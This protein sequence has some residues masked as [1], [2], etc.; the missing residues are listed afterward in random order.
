MAFNSEDKISYEELAPSLQAILNNSI[1]LDT[2]N[3]LN[4]K[5]NNLN[6]YVN[7]FIGGLDGV[8]ISITT[9]LNNISSPVNNKELA[10]IYNTNGAYVSMYIYAAG[11]WKI[12]HAVYA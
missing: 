10:F 6:A 8:R 3:V 11:S 9:S 5:I 1:D 7:T 2:Y 12:V 4:D